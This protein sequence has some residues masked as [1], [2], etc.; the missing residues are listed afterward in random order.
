MN[1]K[2]VK[3]QLIKYKIVHPYA[4]PEDALN[5][6]KQIEIEVEGETFNG[7]PHGLCFV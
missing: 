1:I 2:T 3:Y 4:L 5:L 6:T 7:V